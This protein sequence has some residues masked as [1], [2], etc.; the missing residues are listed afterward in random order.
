VRKAYQKSNEGKDRAR[1]VRAVVRGV[2]L[3]AAAFGTR[4]NVPKRPENVKIKLTVNYE[5]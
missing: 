2:A 5:F 3:V 1:V 4:E